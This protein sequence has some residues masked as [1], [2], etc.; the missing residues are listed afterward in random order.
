MTESIK[1]LKNGKS[2]GRDGF[3]S[4]LDKKFSHLLV[5]RLNQSFGQTFDQTRNEAVITFYSK[6]RERSGGGGF[7][8]T[9]I[10]I[11]HR[12]K[13]LNSNFSPKAEPLHRKAATPRQRRRVWGGGG[14]LT[15]RGPQKIGTNEYNSIKP[16]L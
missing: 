16:L 11:K 9:D 3:G 1:S 5:P 4:E 2:P 7:L 6:S 8:H 15:D 10:F 14:S 13:H 12:S